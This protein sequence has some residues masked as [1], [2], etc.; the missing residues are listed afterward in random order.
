M[1]AR[2]NER[3]NVWEYEWQYFVVRGV[4]LTL[5][6]CPLSSTTIHGRLGTFKEVS[7]LQKLVGHIFLALLKSQTVIVTPRPPMFRRDG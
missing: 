1:D 5:R 7:S 2:M 6:V 4:S 3:W